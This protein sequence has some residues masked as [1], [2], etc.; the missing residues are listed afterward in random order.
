MNR[1]WSKAAVAVGRR[2]ALWGTAVRQMRRT[3]APRWWRRR[4]YLPLP[5]GAYLEFRLI[6]Q[7]GDARHPWDPDDVVN[8]LAWCKAWENPQ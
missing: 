6:T 1:S 3:V 4:P 2:P 7:Y 8:Y 5:S